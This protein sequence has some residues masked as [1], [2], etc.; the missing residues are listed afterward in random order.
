[1]TGRKTPWRELSPPDA[2]GISGVADI[3]GTPD[4][5]T[6]AYT[7]YRRLSELFAVEGLR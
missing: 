6:Y 2:V 3:V 1:V 4:G 7:Y 5:K